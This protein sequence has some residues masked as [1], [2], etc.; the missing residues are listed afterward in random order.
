MSRSG[1]I[2]GGLVA[3][4]LA[5]VLA[6]AGLA[7][8]CVPQPYIVLR[9]LASAS[10]G[11]KVTVEGQ[12]FAGDRHE[13]R[14]NG[15]EGELLA[16]ASGAYF[17]VPFTVP[18]ASPGMYSLVA[19]SREPGGTVGNVATASFEVSGPGSQRSAPR[20]PGKPAKV[21]DGAA[22]TTPDAFV[23]GMA[24]GAATLGLAGAIRVLAR[25]RR[26]TGRDTSSKGYRSSA[27]GPS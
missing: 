27:V 2:G 19:M 5:L 8:A 6:L 21:D 9:P 26:S 25:R 1:S 10:A 7:W 13:I 23:M 22:G 3:A 16:T 18:S 24:G 4:F 12:N 14:W 15:V 17:S 20:A 11:T